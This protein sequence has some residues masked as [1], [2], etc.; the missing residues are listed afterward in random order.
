MEQEKVFNQEVK[1]VRAIGTVLHVDQ[2][3]FLIGE[4]SSENIQP[5][6]LNVV[7]DINKAYIEHLGT[8]LHSLYVR[9]SVSRGTPIE[10]VSDVDC[11]VL[12]R[13]NVT[14]LDL[15]WKRAFVDDLKKKYPF[16]THFDI[17]EEAFDRV[18][19]GQSPVTAF[20]IKVNS[21]C[22]YGEDLAEEL[23][24]I[25]PGPDCITV[26]NWF[27]QERLDNKITLLRS[28]EPIDVKSESMWL[29]KHILRLGFELVMEKDQSY[30][31]DLYPSY[32]IFSKYYPEKERE[33]HNVLE[34]AINPTDDASETLKMLQGIGLW[35]VSEASKMGLVNKNT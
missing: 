6:W 15:S 27:N 20:N 4:S 30:T 31:R 3:G 21:T 28:T 35:A 14:D 13:G 12:V 5:P 1:T 10:G 22:L 19:D 34:M 33:M 8:N 9:G 7:E 26:A 23:E 25:K 2:D 32:E 29:A 11:I 17:D 16:S 24:P 18:L